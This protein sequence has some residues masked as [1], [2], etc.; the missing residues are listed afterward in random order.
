MNPLPETRISLILRL[1]ESADVHAWQ[2]FAELY[3]PAIYRF[4]VQK[5]LQPADA[6]DVTQEVMFGV[7]RAI[8]RFEPDEKRASFRTW[9]SRIARNLVAESCRRRARL[10]RIPLP[11][12][13]SPLEAAL[14]S[15][16]EAQFE[17]EHRVAIFHVAAKRIRKR[18]AADAWQAFWR[19]S[20]A[21]ES[22]VSVASELGMTLGSLYVARSRI[23]KLLRE[24]VRRLE[25]RYEQPKALSSA[26]QGGRDPIADVQERADEQ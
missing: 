17:R 23:M 22:C 6:E 20:V 16:D 10:P 8:E 26:G 19:S 25:Q 4:A 11:E 7:A 21:M 15:N 13:G 2:E 9:L 1:S 14:A 3:A 18:V 12:N 24:E 5:G